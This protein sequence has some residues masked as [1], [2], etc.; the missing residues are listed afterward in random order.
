M[1]GRGYR[2]M[3]SISISASRLPASPPPCASLSSPSCLPPASSV[4]LA[5]ELLSPLEEER[6]RLTLDG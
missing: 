1:R 2:P 6:G 4:S 3:W 5:G